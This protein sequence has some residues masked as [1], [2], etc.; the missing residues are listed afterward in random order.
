MNKAGKL[1]KTALLAFSYSPGVYDGAI[2]GYHGIINYWGVEDASRRRVP[3]PHQEGGAHPPSKLG[4]LTTSQLE[5]LTT[6]KLEGRVDSRQL[7][8]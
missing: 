2:G 5:N 6:G 8:S 4:N 7:A 1:K 3:H